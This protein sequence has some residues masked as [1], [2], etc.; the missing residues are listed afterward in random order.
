MTTITFCLQVTSSDRHSVVIYLSLALASRHRQGLTNKRTD[1]VRSARHSLPHKADILALSWWTKRRV[2]ASSASCFTCTQSGKRASL[3]T[4]GYG[5]L[6][7]ISRKQ[8]LTARFT[9]SSSRSP[10]IMTSTA[11]RPEP[12]YIGFVFASPERHLGRFLQHLAAS[13]TS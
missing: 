8:L 9:F 10:S 6:S 12:I 7:L 4:Q 11:S 13:I 1:D 3:T 5:R 2:T